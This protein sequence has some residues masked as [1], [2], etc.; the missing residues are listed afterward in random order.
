MCTFLYCLEQV[1]PLTYIKSY[2]YTSECPHGVTGVNGTGFPQVIGQAATFN[3][4][5][6]LKTAIAISTEL[7]AAVNTH[8]KTMIVPIS[9][10][11]NGVRY[12]Y[13]CSHEQRLTNNNV[14][15]CR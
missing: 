11:C 4:T 8:R 1:Q 5:L 12:S 10:Y 6:W 3:Q 14:M 2:S 7:R 9:Q 15:A 13:T